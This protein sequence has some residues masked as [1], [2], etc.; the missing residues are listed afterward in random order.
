MR[1]PIHMKRILRQNLLP[2]ALLLLIAA[3]QTAKEKSSYSRVRVTFENINSFGLDSVVLL[4]G[5][6]H[7][8]RV[9]W[10]STTELT[11]YIYDSIK[12][13]II[14]I[15]LLSQY[16][17]RYKKQITLEGDTTIRFKGDEL[18][19]FEDTDELS[20]P[21]DS[22]LPGEEIIII[23]K[24]ESFNSVATQK[25]V[26][27]KPYEK[28]HKVVYNTS[29]WS[30]SKHLKSGNIER[31]LDS[32]E[33][34]LWFKKFHNAALAHA[35]KGFLPFCSHGWRYEIVFRNKIFRLYGNCTDTWKGYV[36]FMEDLKAPYY[37]DA[38][39]Q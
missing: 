36:D 27:S 16:N 32:H 31:L 20:L 37:W 35:Q 33:L 2:V 6:A 11:Y 8:K 23:A 13:G 14:N 5:Y 3:C 10:D 7:V 26:I 4:P 25:T 39:D 1:I 22:L 15:E 18:P 9:N 38:G 21:F 24:G 19:A 28:Q 29:L 34:S 17:A 12:N 30:L